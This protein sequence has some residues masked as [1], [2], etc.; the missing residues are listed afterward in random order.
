MVV[1]AQPALAAHPFITEDPGTLGVG[2]IELEL[3]LA[4][5]QGDPSING[6]ENAFSPQFSLGIAPTIDLIAQTIWLNQIPAQAPTLVG[7][8]DTIADFKWRFLETGDLALAVRAGVDLPTGDSATGLGAG[9]PGYHAIAIA[10]VKLGSYAVYANAG[11]VYTRQP[12]TR[13]NLGA[14]SIALTRPDDA[15][16]RT[17]VEMATFSNVDPGNPQW[18]AVART[19][20][21]YTVN[22]WLDVDAGFQAR[23]N[24]SAT[25]AVWLAGATLR[26]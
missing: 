20:L 11:Y 8:G 22:A 1:F 19:G 25:R 14:L 15:P 9:T 3:G 18:P 5:R 6:R 7:N 4:A 26:W 12:G 23:L 13:A 17:F 21:I 24:R 10:G 16:L 2:H